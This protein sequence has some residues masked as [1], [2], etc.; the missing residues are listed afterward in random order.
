M[1]VRYGEKMVTGPTWE[2]VTVDELRDQLRIIG[3]DADNQ[4]LLMY[5]IAAREYVEVLTKRQIPQAQ[6]E[7]TLDQFPGRYL[8]DAR[9]PTWRYGIIRLPRP[10]L[11]SVDTVEY[12]DTSISVPPFVYTT[13]ATTEYQ[14]DTN[15]E[16]GRLAPAPFKVWPAT[17][18]LA[19][20]AVKVTYTCG[21]T[22]PEKVPARLKQAIRLIAAHLYE[23]REPIVTGATVANVPYSLKAF[24]SSA[25]PWE[26]K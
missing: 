8:D 2:P 3:H 19:M 24:A 23:H 16:P 18:P 15:T 7:Y 21:Y 4:V 6:F 14:V 22:G 20:A 25:A 11:I 9:P 17:S 26:Y 12:Y 5:L 13:L 1:A 10:P